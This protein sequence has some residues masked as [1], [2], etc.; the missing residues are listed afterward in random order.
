MAHSLRASNILSLADFKARASE[1]LNSQKRDGEAVVI[2][3]N[4][5][6]AAVLIPA[7]EY[8]SLVRGAAFNQA[9]ERGLSDARAGRLVDQGSLAAEMA[10][11]YGK[12]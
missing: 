6:A 3:Q 11:R 1:V 4:G 12:P 8:D 10:Q 5:K 7:E 9:V 2:T